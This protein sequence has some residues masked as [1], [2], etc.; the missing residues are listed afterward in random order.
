[1]AWRPVVEAIRG[2][3]MRPVSIQYGADGPKTANALGI[4]HDEWAAS[5]L[6]WQAA[7]IR[8][9]AALVSVQQTALHL[10]GAVG[11][12]V[13]GVVSNKPAWRYGIS[14][15]MPW[16][17]TVAL[18]RQGAE[19]RDW[20]PVMERVAKAVAAIRVKEAA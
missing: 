15:D 12:H 7:A 10:G 8:G 1:M 13:L 19:E 4:D 18:H 11:A 17:Q 9:C 2:M 3:G 16:Y 20:A 14:G 5:D 6:L